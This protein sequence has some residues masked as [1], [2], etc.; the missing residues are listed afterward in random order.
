MSAMAP[1]ISVKFA[2]M[3]G[4]VPTMSAKVAH[5]S[6]VRQNRADKRQGA[7]YVC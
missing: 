6:F 4:K 3:S 1:T 5:M 7:D 2:H